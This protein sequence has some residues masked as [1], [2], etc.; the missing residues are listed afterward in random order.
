MT[1]NSALAGTG[2]FTVA[3]LLLIILGLVF[4]WLGLGEVKDIFKIG[5]HKIGADELTMAVLFFSLGLGS[6]FHGGQ[7]I[8]E[9]RTKEANKRAMP[10]QP[11]Y[12]SGQFIG[13]AAEVSP[14][15]GTVYAVIIAPGLAALSIR[16]WG[17][18]E[19]Y[20]IESVFQIFS[21]DGLLTGGALFIFLATFLYIIYAVFSVNSFVKFGP[22]RI[23]LSQMP[24][25]PGCEFTIYADISAK[26]PRD[27]K[28]LFQLLCYHHFN[29][30][31]GNKSES[32]FV[33]KI[34]RK[35]EAEVSLKTAKIKGDRLCL[36]TVIKIPDEAL[37]NDD[38]DPDNVREWELKMSI[39]FGY[40]LC[41]SAPVYK[42][43]KDAEIKFNP[44]RKSE[45]A[46][47]SLKPSHAANVSRPARP[48]P[49]RQA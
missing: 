48:A 35:I 28:A 6:I 32:D 43:R 22:A 18:R 7:K 31:A 34:E 29:S 11:W 12:H 19:S 10:Q 13:F 1:K 16:V 49:P 26:I 44:S 20:F 25:T 8:R 4:L 15:I 41:V 45:P 30:K 33:T 9:I 14:L 5:L 23:E 47:S 40:D 39:D 42:I 38:S 46:S 24:L 3:Y 21:E 2:A 27:S 37:P 17:A 36:E